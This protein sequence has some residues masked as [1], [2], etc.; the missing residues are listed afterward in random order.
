MDHDKG[1]QT[2][3]LVGT[4][5]Y[6]APE[7]VILGRASKESDI[8]SFGVVALELAC[9][10]KPINPNAKEDEKIMSEWVWELYGTGNLL[11]AADPRLCGDFDEQQLERLMVVGLWCAHP[12]SFSRPSIR[13]ALHVL[14]F[15]IALPILEPK[16][17][18][19][20]YI[21]PAIRASTSSATSLDNHHAQSSSHSSYTGSSQLSTYSA[22][23]TSTSLLS[24]Q[25]IHTM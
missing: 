16:M 20:T 11:K 12:D 7:Y 13:K 17:P 14:S 19:P 8:Y 18:V 23:S 15:E 21:T 4:M 5:G 3:A 24:S 25:S 1:L 9:G 22:A 2:T 10:R 6:M